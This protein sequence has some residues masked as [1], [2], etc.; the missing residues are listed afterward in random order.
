[1]IL[2]AIVTALDKLLDGLLKEVEVASLHCARVEEQG[3]VL[4][5]LVVVSVIGSVRHDTH[6]TLS[7]P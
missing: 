4:V 2:R 3:A 1:V 7:G 5:V 6:G